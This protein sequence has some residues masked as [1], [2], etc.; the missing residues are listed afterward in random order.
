[1][2]PKQVAQQNLV[3]DYGSQIDAYLK[4]REQSL[5]PEQLLSGHEITGVY[6]AKMVDWMVEVMTA[7]KCAEQTFFLAISLMDRY[8]AALAEQ[9]KQ[10]KLQELHVTGI[11][12]MFMASKYEDIYPLLLRTVYQK[13]AHK[14]ISTQEIRE[15]EMMILQT[16]GFKVGA[17]TAQEFSARYI[18][19]VL[20]KHSEKDFISL[21]SLYLGKMGLHH[22]GLCTKKASLMGAAAVYVALKI[23]EQMRQKPIL[24]PEIQSALVVASGLKE[25]ELIDCSKK[26]LYLAQNFEKELP[27]LKN[28]K[29][30][31][32]P[33]LNKFVQ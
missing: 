20:G 13:I 12:C 28:L 31:Y 18:E 14:K 5:S 27:G 23:C 29:A 16:L 8:F 32:I 2:Q 7:F 6:R 22:E 11:T 10:L 30:Y 33:E 21:M 1:M 19:D 26:L 25:R 9:G 15:R 3:R 17:P 4:E 24:T